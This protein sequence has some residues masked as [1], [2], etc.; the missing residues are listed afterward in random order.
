MGPGNR[1][2]LTQHWLLTIKMVVLLVRPTVRSS[3]VNLDAKVTHNLFQ[4]CESHKY[5]CYSSYPHNSG[6]SPTRLHT[7]NGSLLC[8]TRS[9]FLACTRFP[10]PQEIIVAMQPWLVL[11]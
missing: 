9:L 3:Y 5:D 8:I 10:D 2:T 4:Y 1:L 11:G 7:S 6:R